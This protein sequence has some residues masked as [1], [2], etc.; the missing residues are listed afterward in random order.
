MKF[1]YSEFLKDNRYIKFDTKA[2]SIKFFDSSMNEM[3]MT[4]KQFIKALKNGE[5]KQMTIT[6]DDKNANDWRKIVDKTSGY[7]EIEE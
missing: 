1:F 2:S 5:I 6:V 3:Y 4:P 7:S